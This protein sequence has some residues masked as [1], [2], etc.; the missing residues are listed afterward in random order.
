MKWSKHV[1]LAKAVERALARHRV[2]TDAFLRGLGARSSHHRQTSGAPR[3]PKARSE[4]RNHEAS[5]GV[6]LV[7]CCLEVLGRGG[8][9]PLARVADF[10]GAPHG[11]SLKLLRAAAKSLD[12]GG[13]RLGQQLPLVG[14]IGSP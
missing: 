5:G 14:Q 1:I 13:V 11:R 2:F 4:A 12:A 3:A 9:G 6:V 8:E 10:A 7:R